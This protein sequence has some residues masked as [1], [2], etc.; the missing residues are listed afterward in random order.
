[1][2]IRYGAKSIKFSGEETMITNPEVFI[3]VIAAGLLCS[4][5]SA[6]SRIYNNCMNNKFLDQTRLPWWCQFTIWVTLILR[7]LVN[8]DSKGIVVTP[9][10]HEYVFCALMFW[11]YL[12]FQINGIRPDKTRHNEQYPH[13]D[14]RT[15]MGQSIIA[16]AAWD[17]ILFG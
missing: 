5:L 8:Y 1:L 7:L 3:L 11:L 15:V 16:V 6:Y 2:F 17:Y 14:V 4:V 12:P 9:I 10:H 13:I